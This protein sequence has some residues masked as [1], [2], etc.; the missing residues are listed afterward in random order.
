MI[1]SEIVKVRRFNVF[2][3]YRILKSVREKEYRWIKCDNLILVMFV[4]MN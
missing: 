4:E 2:E 3:S 1:D